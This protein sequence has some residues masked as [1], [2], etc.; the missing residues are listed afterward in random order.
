MAAA[1]YLWNDWSNP[2]PQGC[3]EFTGIVPNVSTALTPGARNIYCDGR[4]PSSDQCLGMNGDPNNRFP[5]R[6]WA[7]GRWWDPTSYTSAVLSIAVG[8]QIFVFVAT[9]P[10]ADFGAC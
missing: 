4:P 2:V 6:V 3:R 10:F 9:G 7:S 5:L 8:L 1:A